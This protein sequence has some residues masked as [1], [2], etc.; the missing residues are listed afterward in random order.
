MTEEEE[1]EEEEIKESRN[2][3]IK[4]KECPEGQK[5]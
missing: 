3:G 4:E 5:L 1:E 2:K